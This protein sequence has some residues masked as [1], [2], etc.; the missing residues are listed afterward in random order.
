VFTHTFVRF[1]GDIELNKLAFDSDYYIPRD[2]ASASV[3]FATG[4]WSFNV[5]ANYIS[6]LPNYDEDAWVDSYTTFNASVKYDINDSITASLAVENLLDTAPPRDKTW[7][8]Y[9]YY[10]TSWYDGIGRS[11][12]LQVT[13]KM[14]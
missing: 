9:P 10:N 7:V 3:N 14:Q 5:D 12:F 1:V 2:K 11:A 13:Y 8:S 6:H 4:A